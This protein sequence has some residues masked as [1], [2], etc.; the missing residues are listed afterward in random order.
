MD[1]GPDATSLDITEGWLTTDKDT[2]DVTFHW[3]VADLS[4]QPGGTDGTGEYFDFNF[5][6]G[7]TSYYL[8]AYRS[9]DSGEI[10]RLRRLRR[11][12]RGPQP[13]RCGP[14]LLRPGE[15]RDHA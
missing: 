10:V 11:H 1:G 8:G 2:S 13:A 4:D 7:G 15:R 9:L 12:H 6:L 5:T 3:K 14:G